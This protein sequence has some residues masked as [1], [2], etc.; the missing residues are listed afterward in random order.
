[1][2]LYVFLAENRD[3]L[4][5]TCIFWSAVVSAAVCIIK[6]KRRGHI[7]PDCRGCCSECRLRRG[8]SDSGKCK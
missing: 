3:A 7:S 2:I 6:R 4:I 8:G 5:L 1:M